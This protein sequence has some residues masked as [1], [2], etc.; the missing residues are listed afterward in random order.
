MYI[1]IF[2]AYPPARIPLAWGA[3]AFLVG[4]L[5]LCYP[6]VKSSSLTR[7]GEHVMLRRSPAFLWV[8]VGLVALRVVARAYVERFVS[9]LQTGA[10]FFVLAFGMI[11]PWRLLMLREYRRLVAGPR[12]SLLEPSP[13]G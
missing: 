3:A 9:P 10:I 12:P 13:P 2:P 6:L 8:F 11:L 1:I 5:V 7:Q 4:A